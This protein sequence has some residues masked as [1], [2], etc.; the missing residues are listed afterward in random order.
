MI[1][2]SLM[3]LAYSIFLLLILRK[4]NLWYWRINER[5]DLMK[6]N[7]DLLKKYLSINYLG[8]KN[9]AGNITTGSINNGAENITEKD[10]TS[11]T[12]RNKSNMTEQTVDIKY[13]EKIK[14]VY[15]EDK[16]TVVK[17]HK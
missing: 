2:I 10:A 12:V 8:I 13:W 16:F 6:E 15:G 7:N 4:V 1:L 3:I 9:E 5:V 17:Y 11:I 14:E